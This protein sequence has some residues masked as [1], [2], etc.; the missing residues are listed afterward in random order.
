MGL[1]SHLNTVHSEERKFACVNCDF[2][3]KSIVILNRHVE[4]VHKNNLK[5]L[6]SHCGKKFFRAYDLRCHI[7]RVHKDIQGTEGQTCNFKCEDC[8]ERFL[9]R[10]ALNWHQKKAHNI[11]TPT[12][13]FITCEQCGQSFQTLHKLSVHKSLKHKNSELIQQQEQ[14]QVETK[15]EINPG[16]PPTLQNNPQQQQNIQEISTVQQAFSTGNVVAGGCVREVAGGC[17]RE[18]SGNEFLPSHHHPNTT[19]T[20][21]VHKTD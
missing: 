11:S 7:H 1:R 8:S 20:I 10:R 19:T 17:V 5:H 2:K 18:I 16:P 13:K 3:A 15:Y 14:F 9:D 12:D 6:C 21:H 4:R